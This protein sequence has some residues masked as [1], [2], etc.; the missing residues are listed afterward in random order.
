MTKPS[1]AQLFDIEGTLTALEDANRK[2]LNYIVDKQAKD[3]AEAVCTANFEFVRAQTAAV[4]KYTEYL[5][6]LLKI[7]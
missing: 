1:N 2:A 6:Q 3:V 4:K 7:Q 5:S